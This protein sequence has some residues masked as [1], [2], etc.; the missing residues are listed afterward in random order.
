MNVCLRTVVIFFVM[1]IAC[2][3]IAGAREWTDAT[4]NYCVEA[5]LV[6]FRNGIVRL[7]K[8]DGKIVT[9]PFEKLSPADRRYL[10]REPTAGK[11]KRDGFLVETKEGLLFVDLDG[12]TQPFSQKKVV[13]RPA[14]QAGRVFVLV[15]GALREYNASG[16]LVRGISITNL[17]LT[18]QEKVRSRLFS[19]PDGGF[20]LLSCS[21]DRIFFMD[22]RGVG[23]RIVKVPLPVNMPDSHGTIAEGG[24][25]MSNT[26]RTNVMRVD[27]KTYQTELFM[28]SNNTLG[29]IAFAP[30]SKTYYVSRGRS[31]HAV[32]GNQRQPDVLQAPKVA[33]VEAFLSSERYARVSCPGL[34]SMGGSLT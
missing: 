20:A 29:P 21:W 7:R 33:T 22:R 12:K 26:F 9:V 2:Q 13:G 30:D 4:G 25:L 14:V 3:K 19:L 27:L 23:K 24:L 15:D 17:S 8:E 1:L 31:I 11:S 10:E 34:R 28:R 6:D 5:E 32:K 18:P 16:Q